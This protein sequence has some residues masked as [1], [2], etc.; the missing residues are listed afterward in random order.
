MKAFLI[1]CAALIVIAV[2]AGFALQ[3]RFAAPSS[4][5][6]VVGDAVRL[7]DEQRSDG[8]YPE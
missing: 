3:T 5:R 2:V 7:D 8:R 4:E 6:Y 1:A